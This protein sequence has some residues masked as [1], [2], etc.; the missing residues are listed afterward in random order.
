V[1]VICKV[2]DSPLIFFRILIFNCCLVIFNL[3]CSFFINSLDLSWSE[4]FEMIRNISMWSKLGS[5]SFEVFSHNVSHICSWNF[6]L[7]LFFLVVS[8][9]WL[10]S[11]LLSSQVLI[12]FLHFLKLLVLFHCH[13]IF[14]HSSHSGHV[15]SLLSIILFF[16]FKVFSIEVSFSVLLLNPF[17]LYRS[18]S[19]NSLTVC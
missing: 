6:E 3:F 9:Y 1:L 5:C 18:V 2:L 15:F 16:V 14:E 8:P 19:L 17:F 11:F 7:V 13:F 10:S 12:I 4:P